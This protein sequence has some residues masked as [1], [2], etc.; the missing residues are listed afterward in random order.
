MTPKKLNNEATCRNQYT[1][2]KA[3]TQ[4]ATLRDLA[5]H[6]SQLPM[7]ERRPEEAIPE[8]FRERTEQTALVDGLSNNNKTIPPFDP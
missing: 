2:T 1:L 4:V 8:K 7:T 6:Q 3:Y 5:P